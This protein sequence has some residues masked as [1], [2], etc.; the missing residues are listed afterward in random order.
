MKE[1]MV[2]MMSQQ[3]KLIVGLGNPGPR[4]ENT[5]HNVGFWV[6]DELLRRTLATNMESL[7][8]SLVVRADWHDLEVIFAKPMTYMNRSG[9]AVAALIH[10]FD[11]SIEDVCVVYD[12]IHLDFCMLRM[13]RKGS[14]GGH[15]GMRSIIHALDTQALP[16]LRIGIGEPEENLIDYVLS[17]FSQAE[18]EEMDFVVQ[19]AA[20][21]LETFVTDG[22]QAAMSRFNGRVE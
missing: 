7:C 9:E 20:D 6:I 15:N 4:Y 22:V 18:R 14:D 10:R 2:D 16:R 17:E 12:D 19:R 21:A 5:K 11:A 3:M 13:R 8:Q 1:R